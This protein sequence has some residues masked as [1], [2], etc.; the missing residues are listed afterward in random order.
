MLLV[1]YSKGIW[2]KVVSCCENRLIAA[3]DI[4]S[5]FLMY[6]R[7]FVALANF[8]S[9]MLGSAH[10]EVNERAKRRHVEDVPGGNGH[11]N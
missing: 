1:V 11:Y 8:S 6:Q 7:L 10:D 4:S 3:S 5:K 9:C 2:K